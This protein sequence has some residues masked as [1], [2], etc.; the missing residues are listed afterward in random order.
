MDELR[1]EIHEAFDKQ[2]SKLG[3]LGDSRE[4]LVRGALAARTVHHE[5]QMPFAAGVAALVIATLVIATFAYVRYG[6]G[7]TRHGPPIPASSPT[8]LTRPLDVSNDTPVILYADP[9]NEA[10]V[11]GITWDGT[12]TGKVDW[13]AKGATANPSA[14]LFAGAGGVRDRSGNVVGGYSAARASGIL[15]FKLF[16][17]TWVDDG[18]QICSMFPATFP[19]N[20]SGVPAILELVTPGQTPRGVAQVGRIYEYV[21]T[22]VAACSVRNDRAV[23]VQSLA[24]S[25]AIAE[26]W[27][28]QLSTGKILW[29]HTFDSSSPRLVVASPDGEYVAETTVAPL[30]TGTAIYGADGTLLAQLSGSVDGFCW[31]GSLAVMN[32]GRVSEPV[33]VVAWRSGKVLWTGPAGYI[34]PRVEPQPDGSSLAIWISTPTQLTYANGPHADVYVIASNGHVVAHMH[35][36]TPSLPAS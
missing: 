1:P 32:G 28:V 7:V 17:G 19:I 15:G 27:V 2:Q 26:Y 24:K 29:T 20:A 6:V 16:D 8:P 14:N 30:D 12:Q 18:Q 3:N 35:E 13:P 33:T 10:Q 5:G 21:F 11:D 36:T 4:R 31:D 22:G 23:V 25:P 34:A 9:V